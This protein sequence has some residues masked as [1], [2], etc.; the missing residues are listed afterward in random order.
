M[1]SSVQ[2]HATASTR[3]G[4]KSIPLGEGA[5][6]VV[7]ER[8]NALPAEWDAVCAATP[9][10]QR[11]WLKAFE[12]SGGP[13]TEYLTWRQGEQLVA[14][15]QLQALPVRSMKLGANLRPSLAAIVFGPTLYQFGQALFSGPGGHA[16]LP[17]FELHALLADAQSALAATRSSSTWLLK[18]LPEPPQPNAWLPIDALPEMGMNL[19][20]HWDTFEDYLLDLPSK[21]RRR[22]RRARK[23]FHPLECRLLTRVEIEEYSACMDRLYARLIERSLYVP[24]IVPPGYIAQ[25]HAAEPERTKVLGYFDGDNM[26][27]FATLLVAGRLGIAHYAAIDPS[28]NA[29]HQLYLNLLFDLLAAAIEAKLSKINFGRTATTIKSSLG[30]EPIEQYAFAKH[31]GC[32]RHQLLATVRERIVGDEAN[33]Q[34]QRPLG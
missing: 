30:A 25:L 32:L 33:A 28:Y 1:T 24:Y 20:S 7:Y 17:S 16:C 26:V 9:F 6:L 11:S 5:E 29:S 15:S 2:T 22:A 18:D 21:Y 19:R 10:L 23:K 27:G 3:A 34:I 31:D 8:A 13:D 12:A 14:C 4:K